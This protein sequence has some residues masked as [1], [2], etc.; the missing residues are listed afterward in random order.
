[1]IW[2][3]MIDDETGIAVH[4]VDSE[5]IDWFIKG[6]EQLKH[7][8]VGGEVSTPAFTYEEDGSIKGVG[9]TVLRR[10]ADPPPDHPDYSDSI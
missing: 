8:E 5:G 4:E 10:V 9:E 7:E 2:H 1:M 3:T 6:L